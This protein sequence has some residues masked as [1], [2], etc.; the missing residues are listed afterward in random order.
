VIAVFLVALSVQA[1]PETA[2]TPLSLATFKIP[3]EMYL[4]TSAA[5]NDGVV[6][7]FVQNGLGKNIVELERFTG[8]GPAQKVFTGALQTAAI[9]RGEGRADL[10]LAASAASGKAELTLH[11]GGGPDTADLSWSRNGTTY[12]GSCTGVP[13]P[14]GKGK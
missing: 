4:C 10:K 5:K 12:T 6:S 8:S 11:A 1:A 14:P 3:P 13:L 9:R 7:L 2:W